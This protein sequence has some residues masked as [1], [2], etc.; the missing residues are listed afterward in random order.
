[1]KEY[2]AVEA[3]LNEYPNQILEHLIE[4]VDCVDRRTRFLNPATLSMNTS[5][6]FKR[7]GGKTSMWEF[8][9]NECFFWHSPNGKFSE[10]C[11]VDSLLKEKASFWTLLA[12]I[13]TEIDLESNF[14]FV[15]ENCET[16]EDML[17]FATRK[18]LSD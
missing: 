11:G 17:L 16:L 18:L 10:L 3:V 12:F 2:D 14:N 4:P 6:N 9:Y 8:I 15:L 13:S 5:I 1:M 7:L